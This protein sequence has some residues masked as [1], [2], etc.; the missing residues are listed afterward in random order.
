[1]GCAPRCLPLCCDSEPPR[2][3]RRRHECRATVDYHA[4]RMERCAAASLARQSAIRRLRT[5]GRTT[6]NDDA[7]VACRRLDAFRSCPHHLH[8]ILHCLIYRTLCRY[9]LENVCD[10]PHLSSPAFEVRR[11]SR[12]CGAGRVISQ[13]NEFFSIYGE[14]HRR[15]RREERLRFD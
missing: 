5:H 1:M 2:E 15:I 8:Q 4:F 11:G 14:V 6:A 7:R 3:I 10:V 12:S 13:R 9:G